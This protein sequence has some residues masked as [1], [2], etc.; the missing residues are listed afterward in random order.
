[1]RGL[2]VPLRRAAR[3]RAS[4]PGVRVRPSGQVRR[5]LSTASTRRSGWRRPC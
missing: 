5:G 3:R 1:M 4:R 2:P